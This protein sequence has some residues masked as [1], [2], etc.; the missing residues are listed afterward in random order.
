LE[1]VKE[2]M[3]ENSKENSKDTVKDRY[4]T[5]DPDTT[6]VIGHQRPDTDAIGSALGYAW[7][8]QQ[9]G[10][11]RVK[12]IRAGQPVEQ[13]RFALERFGQTPPRL[14]TG[15][16][17]TFGHVARTQVTIAPDAPLSEAVMH[18]AA[19]VRVVPVVDESNQCHG[20]ITP[21]ALARAA[22]VS[23][24]N[25]TNPFRQPCRDVAERASVFHAQDRLSD[26]RAA[27][28][29]SDEDDFIVVD[30]D[31]NYQGVATRRRILEPPRARLVL[32][33]HNELG[34]AV[35]GADEADIIAV[36]DHHRLGNAPT[37]LPI[38]FVVEPVGST[39]T[40]VTEHCQQHGFQPPV[41]L[42]GMMLSGILSDTLVFRSP[43]TTDRDIEAAAWLADLSRTNVET[44]GN[45]LLRAAPGLTTRAVE[46][47]VDTDRKKYEMGGKN[48]SIAQVEV[49]GFQELPSRRDEI[50]GALQN[51]AQRE[52]L[53]LACVMITDIV[54]GVSI[55]LCQGENW[56]LAS[57]PFARQGE[58]EFD[59]EDIVSRKKQLVPT[60]HA[61]LEEG[62]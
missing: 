61:V 35:A 33:D 55:L 43:T 60:L 24:S 57:L 51:Q 34:Q 29:R 7:F 40:L 49:T 48:V 26:H 56:I 31:N 41:G 5:W 39:C 25:S 23:V 44:Y 22:S 11:E 54:E 19:G 62:R 52:G 6:Y 27:L 15:V 17:P 18:L 2:T 8:L 1:P 42:A 46:E 16:A 21:L 12:A 10:V 30:G 14:L 32:V 9:T 36:L 45:E 13:T 38:P 50:L 3:K 4:E 37:A 53:A 58:H 47:I 20:I 28:L 59:L